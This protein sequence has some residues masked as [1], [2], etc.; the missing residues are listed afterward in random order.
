MNN[1]QFNQPNQAN[2][3]QNREIDPLA[4]LFFFLGALHIY[5]FLRRKSL[6]ETETNQQTSIT[7]FR[8]NH[9]GKLSQLALLALSIAGAIELYHVLTNA[10]V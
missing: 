4:M 1:Y 9:L 5:S 10:I 2:Y 6:Q 3:H 8:I 7:W